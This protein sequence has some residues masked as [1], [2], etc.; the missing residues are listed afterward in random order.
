MSDLS[1]HPARLKIANLVRTGLTVLV[2][3][4]VVTGLSMVL[5]RMGERIALQM[6]VNVVAV[7]ALA[8]Y[9]GNTGIVSFGHGA[10]LALG[11]YFSGILTMPAALQRSALPDLPGFLAGHELSLWVSLPVVAIAGLAFAVLTGSVIARLV[12]ASA[13]IATLGLLIIVHSVAIGAR[14]ITRGS[15]TFYGVPRVTDLAVMV[16]AA[17]VAVIIAR[18]YRESRWGLFARAARDDSDAATALGID[19]R[20]T[21]FLSWCLSGTLATLAGALYGHMLGAFSP[22]S[23]Y[24]PLVFAHVVM[25]IVGGTAAVSGAVVGVI[26]VTLLQDTVRQFEGGATVFGIALPEVFGLTTIVLGLAILLVIWAR[27]QGLVGGF[28]WGPTA[29]A[30]LLKGIRKATEPAPPSA[31]VAPAQLEAD[32]LSKSFAGVKAVAN[33]SFQAPTGRVTGLIGPNGAGK[34]TLVNLL[35]RAYQPDDGAARIGDVDLTRVPHHKVAGFGIARSFQNLRLFRGLTAYENVL[36]AALASGRDRGAAASVTLR[37]LAALD[38]A[39]VAGERADNLPYGARKRLEIARALA[40]EPQILLLDEPA[41]GMNPT[42][43]EDL[44]DRLSEIAAARG[45]GILLIDHD[46]RFVNRLCDW[47][48]VMNRGQ[49]IA[50]GTPDD[51]RNDPSVIEAYI[52]RGRAAQTTTKP[53]EPT[54]E[55]KYTMGVVPS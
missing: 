29:E 15:Q 5:G 42:E 28:E 55:P 39:D 46:L 26:A 34:S 32:G 27:P 10:F 17:I 11:A 20:R 8:I 52:G 45:I 43:T 50:Q 51:I 18:T 49:L 30:R 47:I 9:C 53:D 38:L 24:L 37:E 12:G 4:L 44:G 48:V 23:F 22:A 40:Q 16:G 7:V 31:S 33:V 41:A 19:T 21:R 35:T 14:E 13:T 36:V 54:T 6:A 2:L 3:L 25:M 1:T